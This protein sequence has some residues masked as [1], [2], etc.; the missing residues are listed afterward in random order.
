MSLRIPS[1]RRWTAPRARRGGVLAAVCIA[2]ALLFSAWFLYALRE[3]VEAAEFTRVD[4]SLARLDA[5]PG[6]VDPRWNAE[7][8]SAVR[9]IQSFRIDDTESVA[10]VLDR[11]RALPFVSAVEEPEVLWPD[12]LRVLV[13]LRTPVACVRAGREFVPVC[14]D[15]TLLSGAW[16]TPPQ[17]GPGF[18]PVL[19][20]DDG[21]T[22][23]FRPGAVL[24]SA[25]AQDALAVAVSMWE[26]LDDPSLARLGRA[27]I[28]AR[29]SRCASVEE[30]GTVLLLENGR[31]VLFGRAPSTPEPGELPVE[32]KWE[33]L[34]R[35]LALLP[36]ESPHDGANMQLPTPSANDALDWELVDVRWDAPEILQRGGAPALGR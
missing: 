19:A 10:R 9:E 21:D 25:A 30:P 24:W 13:H 23:G 16:S 32:R 22:R 35:A 1:Q 26:R 36:Q 34:A 31:R 8:A 11:L 12:G 15:G 7:L 14:A 6:W 28:D 4:T 3:D 29:Q 18:L 2:L 27:V 5:G 20:L 33:S 17:C